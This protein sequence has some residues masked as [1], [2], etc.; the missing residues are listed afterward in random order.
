MLPVPVTQA[1]GAADRIE[2][3]IID[4]ATPVLFLGKLQFTGRADAGEAK[5]VG[6][7]HEHSFRSFLIQLNDLHHAACRYIIKPHLF[8]ILNRICS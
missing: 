4:L 6:R 1:Q 8:P 3:R 2:R 5:Q 7:Q